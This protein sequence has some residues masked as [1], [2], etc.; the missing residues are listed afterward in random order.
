MDYEKQKLSEE[1]VRIVADRLQGFAAQ[2]T[3]YEPAEISVFAYENQITVNAA[4]IEVYIQ[5]TF[6]GVMEEKM[7]AMLKELADLVIPLK[8]EQ[9][10]IVPFNLSI[11]K[12][13]WKFK[14]EV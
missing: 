9:N 14:L 8:Q 7:E 4:P 10:I 13:D 6:P 2:V 3:G 1:Q 5:A 11:V 12:M